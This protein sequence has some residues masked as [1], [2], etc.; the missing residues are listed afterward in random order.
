MLR[1]PEGLRDKVCVLGWERTRVKSTDKV[2]EIDWVDDPGGP[3]ESRGTT[4]IVVLQPTV[5]GGYG[6]K[7]R[8]VDL[9]PL[10]DGAGEVVAVG[11][12][13]GR[14]RPGDR[15]VGNFF[16]EWLAG[17]PTQQMRRRLLVQREGVRAGQ[18]TAGAHPSDDGID[19]RGTG[20]HGS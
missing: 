15:V 19:G 12:G 20:G 17:E 3:L 11:E 2:V 8:T 14:F 13:V 10:S 1:F 7:Q 4:D 16:Q 6:S 18:A 5:E 9:I